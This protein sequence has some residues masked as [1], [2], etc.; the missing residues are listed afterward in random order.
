MLKVQLQFSHRR[1]LLLSADLLL[2]TFASYASFL[3][4]FDFEPTPFY[5]LLFLRTLPYALFSYFFAAYACGLNR[6]AYFV[7]S[8]SEAWELAKAICLAAVLNAACVTFL[9]QG[10]YPRSVLLMQPLIA[11][12]ALFAM[13]AS[14]R[15]IMHWL[16]SR[17]TAR[18]PEARVL[19]IGAGSIGEMLLVQLLHRHQE[20][21]GLIDDDPAKWGIRVHGVPVL[22]DRGLLPSLLKTQHIDEIVIAIASKR[23]EI[24]R[25]VVEAT[26]HAAR[27]PEIKIAPSLDEM[28]R[29]RSDGLKIRKVR[30]ADL[31]NRPVVRL[32]T[33]KI[34][35]TIQGKIV[36]VSGAGGTIGS[37]LCRQALTYK[38]TRIVLLENHATAL[39]YRD[40]E[41]KA[42]KSSV[43]IIP[44]LGDV[45]DVG[46][47]D[48][49]FKEYSP[50]VVLHAAAHKHVHQLEFNVQEGVSNNTLGTY[51]LA[52]AADRYG[53]E[54]FLLVSTDKAV[55]PSSVMGA[56][57]RAA[58]IV[59]RSMAQSSKTRFVAVR[60]GN[61]LGSSGSVLRI[62]Q[63]QIAAGG[64][65]TV[66]DADATRYFM[67]VEE[68]VGLILQAASM[69]HGGDIFVLKMG[70]P[71]RIMDMAKN[72]IL[73]SGLEPG[74]DIEISVTGLKQGEKSH[75]ELVEDPAGAEPSEH[76]EIMR[77]RAENGGGITELPARM[78]ELELSM[79]SQ[80][81]KAALHRLLDLVPT[82]KP[83][84]GHGV[85]GDLLGDSQSS[86]T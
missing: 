4:R 13:R 75:E 37:E 85:K 53:A 80:D 69:A 29:S 34:S 47:L 28:L 8:M 26:R 27:R 5:Q 42:A 41:L 19:V 15:R 59:V 61:V 58:E 82:F 71:V 64:P 10:R 78:L 39:F 45:R 12:S 35:R 14:A 16:Q 62:F 31:L 83:S 51:R 23:G 54:V 33:E 43:E 25:S 40:A 24:V 84:T 21:V 55:R 74:I 56:T 63:E 79:R 3:L 72:L 77:L 17:W 70:D 32:D 1:L 9:E 76:P 6:G 66:T 11:F 57:K 44:I 73:L 52:A 65:V 38:P 46:L 68:S 49:V 7:P 86:P 67:T 30:P 2:I 60:F 81:P 18:P 22:G 50:Q 48:R 20:I 36:L